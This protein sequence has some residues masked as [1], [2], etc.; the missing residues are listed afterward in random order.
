[1]Q[2]KV[3][4]SQ[5][6]F[7]RVFEIYSGSEIF[8]RGEIGGKLREGIGWDNVICKCSGGGNI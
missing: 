5:T 6:A 2:C 1:M 3:R 7:L 4:T 8:W